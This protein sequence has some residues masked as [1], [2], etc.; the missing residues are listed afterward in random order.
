M[1]KFSVIPWKMFYNNPIICSLEI[2]TIN[3]GQKHA[4]SLH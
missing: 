2:A 4:N 3:N 1:V